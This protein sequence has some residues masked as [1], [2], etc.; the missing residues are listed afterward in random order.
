MRAPGP[1]LARGDERRARHP[2]LGYTRLLRR[3]PWQQAG[4][5]ARLVTV[6]DVTGGAM[7]EQLAGVRNGSAHAGRV[8]SAEEATRPLN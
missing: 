1:G 6:T 4:I 8:P 7:S 2:P 3:T 5:D